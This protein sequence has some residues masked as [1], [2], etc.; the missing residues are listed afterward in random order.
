MKNKY[1]VKV[2]VKNDYF[3]SPE[4]RYVIQKRVLGVFW[5]DYSDATFQ[6]DWAYK[7]CEEMNTSY[8][9]MVKQRKSVTKS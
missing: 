1:R 9:D 4:T 7:T 8:E 3:K 5:S 6:K 2:V